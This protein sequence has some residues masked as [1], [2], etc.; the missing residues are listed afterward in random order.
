MIDDDLKE[1]LASLQAQHGDLER[2]LEDLDKL[3]VEMIWPLLQS[4]ADCCEVMEVFAGN[5]KIA[6]LIQSRQDSL[7]Y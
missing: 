4:K 2:Q 3:I 5:G 7:S 1:K 6:Y